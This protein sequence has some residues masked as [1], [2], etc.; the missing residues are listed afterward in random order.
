MEIRNPAMTELSIKSSYPLAETKFVLHEFLRH[1]MNF[2]NSRYSKFLKECES[3][4]EKFNMSSEVFLEKFE[5]GELGD[6]EH[7]FDWFASCRGRDAWSRKYNI[8]RDISWN[9]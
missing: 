4:E 3:F 1:Q 5:S 2:I 8:L 6:D 9:E 7:W